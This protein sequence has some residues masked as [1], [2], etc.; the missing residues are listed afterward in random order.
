MAV[1]L[2]HNTLTSELGGIKIAAA[3]WDEAH[4]LTMSSARILGRS[5]SGDGVVEE[6][7]VGS[8]LSLIAGSL[9]ATGG[10]GVAGVSTF[11]TRSGAVTLTSGDVTTAL[12]YTPAAAAHTHAFTDINAVPT[13]TVFY[14]KAAGT[15]AA[16]TQTLATLKTDLGLTGTNG[17]DQSSIVGITGTVAQFNT[18]IT[19]G[20]LATGGGTAT[21]TNTGDQF[22]NMP[23]NRFLGQITTTTGPAEQLT[24]T[25]ATT[26]LDLATTSLKGLQSAADKTKLDGVAT[27]ATA[28]SSDAILLARGNHTGT[29]ASTTIT[30]LATVATSG[31]AADLAGNLAVARLNAGTGASATTFWRGD[32]TWGTPAG[33]GAA[34]GLGPDG[35]KGDITVGGSGTTLTIDADAVTA[36]K[37]RQSVAMSVVG[38][39]GTTTGNV[40]DIAS[41]AADQV[42]R[43]SAAGTNLAFGTVATGG[44]ADGAITL[45]KRANLPANT[46][47][48]NNTGASAVTLALTTAQATAMLDLG[49]STLKGLA[50]ASGGGTANFLRADLTWAAPPAGGGSAFTRINGSS[51]AAGADKTLQKLSANAAANLTTVLLAVMTTTDVGVG[52]WNFRYN[53]IYQSAAL[54]TGVDFAVGHSG[55]N[56]SFVVSSQF[57]TS[58]GAAATG[59]ADQTA[60]N[61]ATMVEG[62]AARAKATKMGTTLGVDT[63]N[64]DMHM[65]IEGIIVVTATG[66]LT[67]EHCSELAASTQVMADTTLELTK[68]G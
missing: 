62:K 25:Q 43:N 27:G 14:R 46:I 41:T 59:T 10:G 11:N 19:D 55:T 56:G 22:T 66:S 12:T 52:T 42:L 50:P 24:G 67:L 4:E 37:F 21:G 48:G 16:E 8:G 33:G 15:G 7:T 35:D 29:Q 9:T 23:V 5:T 31:S 51:G 38:R 58:G 54:T 60:G 49:T 6:I 3:Q 13:A 47:T 61:L 18:A 63:I 28:N 64:A 26:L 34:D 65:V 39:A 30:G 57:V 20:D 53:V 45:A 36:A 44:I 1:T 68:I 32:G 17:G 2:R 40:V